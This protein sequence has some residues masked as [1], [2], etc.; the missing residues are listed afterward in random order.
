[1][2]ANLSARASAPP[3]I[4]KAACLALVSILV[5]VAFAGLASLPVR[6]SSAKF[7]DVQVSVQTAQDLPY[8][9]AVTAYNTSGIQVAS[10]QSSYPAAAFELPDGTY[11][12]TVQ[13]TYGPVFYPCV[14]CAS[15]AN[16]TTGNSTVSTA[17]P[18]MAVEGPLLISNST[19]T[20]STANY[21][22]SNSTRTFIPVFVKANSTLPT[23]ST[24]PTNSTVIPTVRV[25]SSN[26]YGYAIE[27]VS[28]PTTLTIHTATSSSFPTAR[29][30]IHVT[31]AN[32]TAATG[33]WVYASVIDDYYY[34]G[35]DFVSSAQVGPSGTAFLTMPEAPLLVTGYLSVPINIP[36]VQPN[37]TVNVG[38]QKVNVTLYIQPSFV[39]LE[40]QTLILP[41]QTSGN[42]TL[43]YEPDQVFYPV[44][45]GVAPGSSQSGGQSDASGSS[46]SASTT[47]TAGGSQDTAQ[48]RIPPFS[49]SDGQK[50][51]AATKGLSDGTL[52][53]LGAVGATAAVVLLTAVLVTLRGRH[54]TVTV[55]AA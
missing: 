16:S 8:T 41:P 17:A 19:V 20:T 25:A 7:N 13:A 32:G 36:G 23:N 46:G 5:V 18:M 34:N 15:S 42:I 28:G 51:A 11:L 22:A 54:Q 27:D 55:P 6:A 21:T 50:G 4:G 12:I 37:V 26:E 52:I 24:S 49:P 48:T 40:G 35:S 9:Y 39:S 3:R 30:S 45:L 43:H 29:I 14:G 31:Y 47:S 10:Y 1:M 44:P 2:S 38:G 33:A 53:V